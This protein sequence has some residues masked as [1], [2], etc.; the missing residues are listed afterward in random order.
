MFRALILLA[1]LVGSTA[2]AP[3]TSRASS[4]ALKMDFKSEVGVQPPLGFWDPLG[5][6]KNADQE[7]F[8]ALRGYEVKHGESE[9][10]EFLLLTTS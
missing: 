10:D 3:V 7:R 4:S 6:L 5:L 2:F 9:S 8:D 1:T